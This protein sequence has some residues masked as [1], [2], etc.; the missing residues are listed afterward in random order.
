MKYASTSVP[1][2][3]MLTTAP[4]SSDPLFRAFYDAQDRSI[5]ENRRKRCTGTAVQSQ[6]QEAERKDC[7]SE[8]SLDSYIVR[9]SQKQARSPTTGVTAHTF[10]PSSKKVEESPSSL[11][12]AFLSYI[13][14]QASLGYTARICL[15]K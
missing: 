10:N 13:E 15:N 9:T 6:Y 5:A 7:K 14:F 8:V 3:L 1:L 4:N 11:Q 2:I 12:S